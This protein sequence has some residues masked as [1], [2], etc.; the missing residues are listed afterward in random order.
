MRGGLLQRWIPYSE[1]R[2]RS[3]LRSWIPNQACGLGKIEFNFINEAP[4]P[5]FAW[6]ERTHDGVLGAVEMLSGVF[7]L[8]RVA[9]ADVAALHAQAEMDPGVAHFQALF[10]ALGV[11]RYLVNMA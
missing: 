2:G 10:A 3:Q 4:A 7:V 5:V 1:S 8:G 6:F 9:A 11:L